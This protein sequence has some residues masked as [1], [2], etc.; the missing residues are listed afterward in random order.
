MNEC[1]TGRHM[2]L[3]YG[4]YPWTHKQTVRIQTPLEIADNE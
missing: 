3:N 1:I 4:A 2:R